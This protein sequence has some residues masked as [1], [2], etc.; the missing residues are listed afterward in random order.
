MTGAALHHMKRLSGLLRCDRR[1]EHKNVRIGKTQLMISKLK[2][3]VGC[4]LAV[5]SGEAEAVESA[6][7]SVSA[8]RG[9]SSCSVC[10]ALAS[11]KVR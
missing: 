9:E 1:E 4:D 2:K 6:V 11:A 3:E 5:G 7:Q 10:W 8:V